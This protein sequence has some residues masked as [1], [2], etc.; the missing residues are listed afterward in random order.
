M[1]Q[2]GARLEQWRSVQSEFQNWFYGSE[3]EHGATS[4]HLEFMHFLQDGDVR[5][6]EQ[7]GAELRVVVPN[8]ETIVLL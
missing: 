1:L 8:V 7:Q 4:L 5:P 3:L 6:H 2:Y